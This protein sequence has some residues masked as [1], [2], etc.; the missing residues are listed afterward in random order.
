MRLQESY[1]RHNKSLSYRITVP[2]ALIISLGWKPKV[3]LIPVIFENCLMIKKSG[4][5]TPTTKRIQKHQER[6]LE[7][8][9]KVIKKS[10]SYSDLIMIKSFEGLCFGCQKNTRVHFN[11][12]DYFYC[13]PC[14]TKMKQGQEQSN[15]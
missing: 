8:Q 12:G 4:T 9:E 14:R 2:K 10:I 5:I 1:D 6:Q 7:L 13:F 15:P 3:E 11:Y